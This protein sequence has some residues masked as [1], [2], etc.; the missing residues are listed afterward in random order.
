MNADI[1]PLTLFFDGACPICRREMQSLRRRDRARRLRFEDVRAPGFATPPG[2]TLDDLLTALHGRTA[3]GGLVIG[4][5]TVRLAYRAVGLGWLL[6]PTTW[7][8]LRGACEHA[9]LWL[10]RHRFALPDWLGLATFGTRARRADCT[11]SS[12][13]L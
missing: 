11:D 7:P 12:C 13:P 4:V 6:A 2:A 1:Y 5:E 10:A 3:R 9:Y 8:L